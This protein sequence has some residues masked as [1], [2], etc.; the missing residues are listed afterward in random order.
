MP[1]HFMI[2]YASVWNMSHLATSEPP[3]NDTFENSSSMIL[4]IKKSF[5]FV[6][7]LN[8]LSSVCTIVYFCVPM[9]LQVWECEEDYTP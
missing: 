3:N 7:K 4:S 2:S 8:E 6:G 5:R 1:L 9:P